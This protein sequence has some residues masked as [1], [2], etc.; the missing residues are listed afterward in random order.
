MTITS[1]MFGGYCVFF[2]K[3]S[4]QM[5]FKLYNMMKI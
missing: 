2:I 1:E 3:Q 4:D 5:I